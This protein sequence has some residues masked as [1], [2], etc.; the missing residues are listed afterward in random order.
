MTTSSD[1]SRPLSV[2]RAS[3]LLVAVVLGAAAAPALGQADS[4]KPG[5]KSQPKQ[6]STPKKNA[7]QL[8]KEGKELF[9]DG[10][11]KPA[12]G[13]SPAHWSI[14][15]VSFREGE[16]DAEAQRGLERVRNL[17]GLKDA[18][19]EKRGP[20]TVIAYGKYETE[21][22][23]KKDLER[24]RKLS[25]TEAGITGTPFSTAMLAPP[26][27]IKGS[28]PEYD[29]R[30]VRK[31]R[32]WAAYTL[33]VGVYGRIDGAP[34]AKELDEFRAA[35][36]KAAVQLRREG[37]EAYYVHG[38]NKSMVT[39]GIFS[40]EDF[41]SQT[42]YEAPQITQ[43]RKRYPYNLLNGQGVR[44]TVKITD[45]KTGKVTR[46]QQLQKSALTNIPKE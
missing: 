11:E 30:N 9:G 8:K 10:G 36:E 3:V 34:T 18:Y 22:A 14:V 37:E 38:P 21:A 19:L 27:E 5:Q 15:L 4:Y 13:A 16:Q 35:A 45:P 23:G 20:A 2:P 29:L 25:V 44:H 28:M 33:Q 1:S 17:A 32:E 26:A 31:E 42:G 39:V 46:Q 40:L 41:D 24:I 12:E 43:L 6:K 7:E